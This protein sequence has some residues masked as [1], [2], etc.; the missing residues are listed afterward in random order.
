MYNEHLISG[1]PNNWFMR[2]V[3]SLINR[4]M[5]KSKSKYRLKIRYRSPKKGCKWHQSLRRE[6]AKRLSIYIYIPSTIK[7]RI[8]LN[9]YLNQY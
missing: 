5:K 6:E 8:Q 2:K 7:E 1:L 9:R 3:I 4:K